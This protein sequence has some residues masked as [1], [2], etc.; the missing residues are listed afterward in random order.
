MKNGRERSS[1]PFREKHPALGDILEVE[2]VLSKALLDVP[3]ADCA[4]VAKAS[5][6]TTRKLY[7]LTHRLDLLPLKPFQ[8]PVCAKRYLRGAKELFGIHLQNLPCVVFCGRF[9]YHLDS[10]QF[11]LNLLDQT[12]DNLCL[13]FIHSYSPFW[14]LFYLF[15]SIARH[16]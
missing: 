14:L 1:R 10:G 7:N 11:E 5:H 9:S 12:L 4:E 3:N 2:T 16:V 6:V 13:C 15:I 8:H